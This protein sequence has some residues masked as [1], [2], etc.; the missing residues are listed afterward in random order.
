MTDI[1]EAAAPPPCEWPAPEA[2]LAAP[3]VSTPDRVTVS[4]PRE[5]PTR[6]ESELLPVGE[7]VLAD[8]SGTG[9]DWAEG[10]VACVHADG[11]YDIQYRTVR[12]PQR[13]VPADR[14]RPYGRRRRGASEPNQPMDVDPPP[15]G[16]RVAVRFSNGTDYAG[17]IKSVTGNRALIHYDDGDRETITFPE[18]D[19]RVTRRGPEP[20]PEPK[21]AAVSCPICLDAVSAATTF[22]FACSHVICGECCS[23]LAKVAM[24]DSIAQRSGI[25]VACPICRRPE[26]VSVPAGVL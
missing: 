1:E 11:F 17:T 3:A 16:S 23:T 2:I 10:S 18:P 4:P 8:R 22:R 20:A 9:D 14:V 7:L 26:R 25:K 6:A 12:A 15:P 5:S 13:R 24:E 19:V 21:A